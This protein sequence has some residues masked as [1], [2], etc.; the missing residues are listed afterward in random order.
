MQAMRKGIVDVLAACV[1]A[2]RH[3]WRAILGPL[4]LM[5]NNTTQRVGAG[6]LYRPEPAQAILLPWEKR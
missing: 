2:A 6:A 4:K 1:E 3:S 5:A